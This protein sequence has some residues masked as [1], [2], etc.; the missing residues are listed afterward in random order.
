[1][2]KYFQT[3]DKK[4]FLRITK[5]ATPRHQT[6]A[7]FHQPN[8]RVF[9]SGRNPCIFSK[10][11]PVKMSFLQSGGANFFGDEILVERD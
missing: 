11:Q 9:L 2:A 6:M 5:K 4:S 10:I 8:L 1:M 7:R 3:T